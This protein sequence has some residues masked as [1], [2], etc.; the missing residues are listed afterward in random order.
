LAAL[1][2]YLAANTF[3][4]DTLSI[5]SLYI[6]RV[7]G[8]DLAMASAVGLAAAGFGILLMWGVALCE[9]GLNRMA[10]PGFAHPA[11]G[12]LVVGLLALFTPQILSSGHGAI[13]LAAVLDRPLGDLAVLLLLK[14]LASV[15]SLGSGFRGGMFFSSLLMG[16]LGGQMFALALSAMPPI[17]LALDPHIYAIIEM[18]ALSAS[19][20]GGPLTMIFI[21]LETTG[22][23]WLT[24]AVVI[25]VIISAQVTREA[26]GYSFAPG[27][28]TFAAKPSAALPTSAGCVS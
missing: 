21:A 7:A 14:A 12:G 25:A 13:R 5:G 26:F 11:L 1:V 15:V 23:F 4:P 18:G 27:I 6:S 9:R 16:A 19:V 10:M 24:T 2:G 3:D 28:S 8:R 22:D 17:A 20:I